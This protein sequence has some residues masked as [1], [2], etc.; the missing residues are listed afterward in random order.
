MMYTRDRTGSSMSEMIRK[1]IYLHKR[2]QILLDQ[3]ARARGV[4]QAEVIRRALEREAGGHGPPLP[5]DRSAWE[6]ILEAVASRRVL[7]SGGAAY[8]WRRQDGYPDPDGL[9]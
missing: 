8:P 1:Q 3:L 7:G 2:H 9:H 4:S 6:E 5:P